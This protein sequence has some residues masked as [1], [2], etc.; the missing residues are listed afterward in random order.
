M[1][2]RDRA[3][4]QQIRESSLGTTEIVNAI[5]SAGY[6]KQTPEAAAAVVAMERIRAAMD[7]F[8]K[9]EVNQFDALTKIAEHLGAYQIERI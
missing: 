8:F 9:G 2:A 5:K 4:A 7:A 6:A 1:S 3:L